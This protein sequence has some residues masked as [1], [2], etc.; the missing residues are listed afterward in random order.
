MDRLYNGFLIGFFLAVF[1][2]M[3]AVKIWVGPMEPELNTAISVSQ[4]MY[5]ITHGAIYADMT[6]VA[7]WVNS[8]V[9]KA[10]SIPILGELMPK[11]IPTTTAQII[12]LLKSI[13]EASGHILA[14]LKFVLFLVQISLPLMIISIVGIGY[15]VY[16]L[17]NQ[18]KKK[19]KK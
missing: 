18:E 10:A 6:N 14:A 12:E 8:M 13:K 17:Q 9:D 11:G 1:L 7:V 5:D 19:K 4:T 2:T 15:G 3:T 16:D